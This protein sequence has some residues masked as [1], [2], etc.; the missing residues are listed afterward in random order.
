MRLKYDEKF[1]Y[2]CILSKKVFTRF[3]IIIIT[4]TININKFIL[5]R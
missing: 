2:L 4:Y 5:K 1:K 3:L